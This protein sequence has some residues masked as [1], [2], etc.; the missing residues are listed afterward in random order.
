MY[1]IIN[2]YKKVECSTYR[3][4]KFVRK[5]M[6]KNIA[7]IYGECN[8][9]I[10][11]KALE[12][13][14]ESILDYTVKY[15]ICVNF[16]ESSKLEEYTKIYVG[17][18]ETN[19]YIKEHSNV[20]LEYPQEYNISVKDGTV[21]IEGSDECGVLYG[22]TD[23]YNK[24]IVSR[25]YIDNSAIYWEN[26]F[27]RPLCD[28]EYRSH[29]AV[30]ER[31]IWTWGHVIYNYRG[32]IDNMVKLKLNAITIWNDHV[33][34]NAKEMVEYAHSAGIKVIWGYSWFWDTDCNKIDVSAVQDSIPGILE[35]YEKD[36]LPLGGDGIYFQSFTELDKEYIGDV[37]IAKAVTDFVN[38][39]SAK[40]F[41]K[42]PDLELQFGLHA[43]SV[44][45]KLEYIKNVDTRVRIVWE[46]CGA[47]PFD[48]IPKAVENFNETMEFV[49]NIAKLRGENDKFGVVTKGL[50]KLKWS[51]FEHMDGS[52]FTGVSSKHIRD[53][54]IRRKNPI[55]RY[56]QSYWFTNSN[57]VEE[58]IKLMTDAKRGNLYI[59]A[60]VEDG[61]FE[62][63]IMFP[64]A[65]YAEILWDPYYDINRHINEVSLRN[66]VEFAK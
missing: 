58:A 27:E 46:N 43:N 14:T 18:K 21:I 2:T 36:Y 5:N 37:L 6:M 62:E 44:K 65:L 51:S 40:F 60:L 28:F 24:Y 57:Y 32:F 23:F 63:N 26:P 49:G 33:P 30:S 22:C 19:P 11:K 48:Y 66:Y 20:T 53:N 8:T 61:M 9:G 1:A 31:G 38:S 7:I 39:A 16:E 54:R 41:E 45:Q 59:S 64:V 4:I 3:I 35:K 25:E 56:L 15:P 10:Q 17:T 52:I 13:L 47:F 29:P 12:M 55:W 42:Y 50:T 34:A